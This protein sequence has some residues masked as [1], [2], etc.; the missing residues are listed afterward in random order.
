[1]IEKLLIVLSVIFSVV[2]A[3]PK[4]TRA[5]EINK[6][7]DNGV[8]GLK[9]DEFQSKLSVAIDAQ[10]LK[11]AQP[12]W[13]EF[14]RDLIPDASLRHF[15]FKNI[16]GLMGYYECHGERLSILNVGLED[17]RIVVVSSSEYV[18]VEK[19]LLELGKTSACALTQVLCGEDVDKSLARVR[20]ALVK[21]VARGERYPEISDRLVVVDGKLMTNPELGKFGCYGTYVCFEWTM[22][23]K[24]PFFSLFPPHVD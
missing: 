4:M 22:T 8:V 11:V 14:D 21:A 7:L 19:R 9:C 24:G 5:D 2:I 6:P 1:M 13:V 3:L 10:G 16:G 15:N 12:R 18:A 17:T 20:R 23:P